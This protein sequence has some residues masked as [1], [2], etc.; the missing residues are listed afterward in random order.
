MTE[1][2]GEEKEALRVAPLLPIESDRWLAREVA[3]IAERHYPAGWIRR[4]NEYSRMRVTTTFA[5]DGAVAAV[6]LFVAMFLVG[7]GGVVASAVVA[8]AVSGGMV[9]WFR[10]MGMGWYKREGPGVLCLADTPAGEER[11]ANIVHELGHRMQD[12]VPGLVER[13]REFLEKKAGRRVRS[14]PRPVA[15]LLGLS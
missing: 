9:L 12:A 14:F 6:V 2:R 5:V 13:E 15:A 8:A 7:G 3:E 10:R 4:S 11:E 1:G